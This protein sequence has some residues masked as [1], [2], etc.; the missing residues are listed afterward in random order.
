[1][2]PE[3]YL[4]ISLKELSERGAK[5]IANQPEIGYAAAL[6]QVMLLKRISKLTQPSKKTRPA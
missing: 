6:R 1:M 2:I 4:K 3:A 5:I